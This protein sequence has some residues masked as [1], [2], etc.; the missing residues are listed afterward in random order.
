MWFISAAFTMKFGSLSGTINEEYAD[1]DILVKVKPHHSVEMDTISLLRF[2]PDE[3]TSI[4]ITLQNLGNYNDTF[5]FRVVSKHNDIK[6][7][8]PGSITLA[9]GERKDTF[10]GVLVPMSAFDYGTIHEIK[11]EAYSIDQPNITI[12]ERTVILE[13]RGVYVSEANSSGLVIFLILIF[14]FVGYLMHRKKRKLEKILVKPDKPWEIPEEK[15]YLEQIK[16]KNQDEYKE[17][18]KMMK[19]EYNSSLLWYEDFINSKLIKRHIEKEKPIKK[20]KKKIKEKELKVK[21]K[22]KTIETK[23]EESVKEEKEAEVREEIVD[24]PT[25][26]KK[27]LIENRRKEKSLLKIQREQE[28]QKKKMKKINL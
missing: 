22:A 1:V 27:T 18:L 16:E 20:E 15:E 11:I 28:K 6:L 12:G 26:D 8:D 14:L 4:P 25:I 5:N 24:E 17:T 23:A 19:D 21:D 13:S 3:I 10:L 9:P 7:S 2:N